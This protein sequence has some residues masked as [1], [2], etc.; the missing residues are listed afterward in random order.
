M[1]EFLREYLAYLKLERNLSENTIVSY[2]RDLKKVLDKIYKTG[3]GPIFIYKYYHF[4]IYNIVLEYYIMNDELLERIAIALE[5]ISE[6]MENSEKRE[7]N[8][9]R[10]AL[11]E[12]RNKKA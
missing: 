4:R 7:V 2:E 3:F 8:E 10:K 12:S 6:L 9:K 1:Q 5:K 11:K